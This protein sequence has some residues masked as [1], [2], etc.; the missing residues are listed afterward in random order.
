M[1]RV[2][3]VNI[4]MSAPTAPPACPN[5]VGTEGNYAATKLLLFVVVPKAVHAMGCL[6]RMQH[7]IYK[8]IEHMP[9][10]MIK[11]GGCVLLLQG[12]LQTSLCQCHMMP[13][14]AQ[15]KEHFTLGI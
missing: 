13:A 2:D 15:V 14:V 8:T 12:Y 11:E 4:L 7:F 6:I 5:H 9:L 3:A 1:N 10:V